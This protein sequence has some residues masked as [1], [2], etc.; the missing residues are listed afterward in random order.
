MNLSAY[1]RAFTIGLQD[2][3]V[4]RASFLLRSLVTLLP[5]TATILLWRS[6]A[7]ETGLPGG[8]SQSG[9][10]LY[11]VGVLLV[12][13]L[14]SPTEDEWRIAAEIRE[15]QISALLTKP[16]NHLAYRLTLFV[17]YRIVYVIVT[18]P[19]I[20]LLLVFLRAEIQWPH[21]LST[22]L[23]FGLASFGSALLQF[24]IAYSVAM[25]AFWIL[26]ISTIVFI[27]YS[28]EY[29]LSGHVFPIDL[30]PASAR[31]MLAWTPFPSELFFPLQILLE[32][33]S[34]A[35]ILQ[36]FTL[37][38]IWIATAGF[39]ACYL[40]NRGVQRYQGVGI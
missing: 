17:A 2:T 6:L 40:W 11:F 10:I 12:D 14:A 18:L 13:T 30:L 5:L 36:G 28:F 25:L 22:W 8:Y 21:H 19:I 31:Q 37:Q 1:R 39:C 4:Y 29:F 35:E 32:K 20:L 38:S 9:L 23:L 3:F 26:E 16:L 24:F 34:P 15:G 27:L 7:G 33:L